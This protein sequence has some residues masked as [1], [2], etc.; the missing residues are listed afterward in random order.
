MAPP[1]H[2]IGTG[3]EA[4]TTQQLPL[5]LPRLLAAATAKGLCPSDR[6]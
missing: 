1:S 6:G 5:P 2:V 3:G 4:G